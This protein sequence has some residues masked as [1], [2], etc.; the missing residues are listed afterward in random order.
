MLLDLKENIIKNNITT[1]KSVKYE[2]MNE[3]YKSQQH[4]IRTTC[5]S[6]VRIIELIIFFGHILNKY[7]LLFIR[8]AIT[9]DI[10]V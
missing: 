1:C 2:I 8:K 6:Q 5:K 9:H 10:I 4:F 3:H 7:F